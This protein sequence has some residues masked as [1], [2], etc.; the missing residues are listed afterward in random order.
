MSIIT[1][2]EEI[3]TCSSKQCCNEN[4]I[5]DEYKLKERVKNLDYAC[6]DIRV[7]YYKKYLKCQLQTIQKSSIKRKDF[8]YQ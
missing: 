7:Q 6:N 5:N 8:K 2:W 3:K 4:C 1:R